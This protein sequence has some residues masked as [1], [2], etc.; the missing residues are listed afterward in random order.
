MLGPLQKIAVPK[1]WQEKL[2]KTRVKIF[3]ID[4]AS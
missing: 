3:A 2:A 4:L 1:N